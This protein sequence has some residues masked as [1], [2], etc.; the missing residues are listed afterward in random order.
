M[1]GCDEVQGYHL[2]RPV[3]PDEFRQRWLQQAR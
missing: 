1:R 2:G 3:S